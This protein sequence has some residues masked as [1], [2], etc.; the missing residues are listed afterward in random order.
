MKLIYDHFEKLCWK[1]TIE[2]VEECLK[3]IDLSNNDYDFLNIVSTRNDFRF[4]EL[5]I[6]HGADIHENNDILLGV[7]IER[8][9]YK[10]VDYLI[11][12]HKLDVEKL[13]G[14]NAYSKYR[15]D[16]ENHEEFENDLVF[17]APIEELINYVKKHNID[18]NRNNA[19][20][21]QTLM[22]R[23]DVK[24]NPKLFIQFYDS[25]DIKQEFHILST[26]SDNGFFEIVK[27]LVEKKEYN[28]TILKGFSSYSNYKH[29]HEYF[30]RYQ[31]P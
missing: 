23:D 2:E 14:T 26:A 21:I 15:N 24:A 8:N 3:Y 10:L 1:G 16:I 6:K 29:I 30:K 17:H 18:L 28:P 20:S 19:D 13:K 5:F 7:A 25:F 27:Y 22:C 31:A 12:V 4:I 9:N 11:E